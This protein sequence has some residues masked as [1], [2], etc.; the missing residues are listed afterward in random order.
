[1]SYDISIIIVSWNCCE[2][3]RNC[4]QSIFHT[5]THLKLEVIVID[6]AS[7]D[8]S[9]SMVRNEFPNVQLIENKENRGFAA[10]N[11][12]G[13]KISKGRYLLLLNPDTILLDDV[14][15]KTLCIA[16]EYPR[17]AV[18]GCQVM[19]S[20]EKIQKTCFAFS[21]P[22]NLFLIAMG[23]PRLFPKSHFFGRPEISWWDR[24][25]E[26]F[27]DVVSGMYMLVRREALQEVGSM[28]E[29]YFVYAEEADW[30]FRFWQAGW[31][32]MFT[33]EA[34]ILHV[35]GGGKSTRLIATRM[36]VQREKST[37]IFNRK[38]LG[39]PAFLSAKAIFILSNTIRLLVW[40]WGAPFSQNAMSKTNCALAGIRFHLTGTEPLKEK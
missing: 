25:T 35:D 16:E 18:L 7:R 19:E 5:A 40:G 2:D 1:M 33:P 30:C 10:A 23:L 6:N 20:K 11:N 27:V 39:Y 15:K 31:K 17:V 22:L 3:L 29:A 14:L 36:F 28:D 32:C 38:N 26:R 9:A 8:D 21:G 24:T 34:R 12:Q 13:L 4:L 37:V